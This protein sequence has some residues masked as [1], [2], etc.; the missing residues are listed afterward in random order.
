MR[1]P[2]TQPGEGGNKAGGDPDPAAC[3]WVND[4][5][6]CWGKRLQRIRLIME[7][8]KTSAETEGIEMENNGI[9][10]RIRIRCDF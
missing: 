9:Q 8:L 3:V 2:V 1:G 10:Q 5:N 4:H 6:H 7:G